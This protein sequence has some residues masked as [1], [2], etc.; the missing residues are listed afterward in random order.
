VLKD[1]HRLLQK[2]QRQILRVKMLFGDHHS[3]MIQLV[4]LIRL[5]VWLNEN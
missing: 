2:Y 4:M 1:S 5:L 3:Y